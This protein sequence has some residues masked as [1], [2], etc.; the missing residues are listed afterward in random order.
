METWRVLGRA[1]GNKVSRPQRS[2]YCF[3]K[4]CV[5]R[6]IAA[7]FAQRV[8][9]TGTLFKRNPPALEKVRPA[10]AWFAFAKAFLCILWN[11]KDLSGGE[12]GIRTHGTR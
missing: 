6:D 3:A 2:L 4:K 12:G 1:L 8:S 11:I 10:S 7:A 9:L 5:K